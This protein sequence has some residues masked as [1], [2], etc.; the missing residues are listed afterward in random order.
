[1]NDI[2]PR[3]AEQIEENLKARVDTFVMIVH[4]LNEK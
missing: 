1:V 3:V 4:L 2:L